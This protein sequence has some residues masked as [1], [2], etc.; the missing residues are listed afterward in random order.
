MELEQSVDDVV[1]LEKPLPFHAVA[2]VY[3]YWHDVS[4]KE[5][6]NLLKNYQITSKGGV[7]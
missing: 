5:V 1:I 3:R 6:L 7:S 4:D 2:Q